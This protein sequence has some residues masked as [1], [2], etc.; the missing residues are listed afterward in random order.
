MACVISLRETGRPPY[1]VENL[2]SSPLR[3]YQV[4]APKPVRL[5]RPYQVTTPPLLCPRAVLL[6]PVAAGHS[7]G[8]RY[9]E[10]YLGAGRRYGT[11]IARR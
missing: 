5:V 1:V 4:D 7:R 6:P 10:G 2:S 9:V 3:I 11:R 8:G